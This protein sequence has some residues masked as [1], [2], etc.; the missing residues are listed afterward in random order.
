L[1]YYH[2]QVN[3]EKVLSYLETRVPSILDEHMN[4]YYMDNPKN[5][6]TQTSNDDLEE[7]E[8][9]GLSIF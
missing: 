2:E 8:F 1:K 3:K 6:G 5:H 7:D 4:S 9:E